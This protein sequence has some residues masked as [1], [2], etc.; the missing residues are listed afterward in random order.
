MTRDVQQPLTNVQL[1]LLK[2]FS[3][4]L[5]EAELQELKRVLA[6]FFAQKAI[7]LADNAWELQGWNEQKVEKLLSTKLRARSKK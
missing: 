6:N 5:P 7:A 2:T 1:E 4:N 3:Y